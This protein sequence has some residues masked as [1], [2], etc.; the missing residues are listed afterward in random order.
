MDQE[1]DAQLVQ[2][3]QETEKMLKEADAFIVD[4]VHP[5]AVHAH[6]RRI[7]SIRASLLAAVERTEALR[8]ELKKS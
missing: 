1:L 6:L 7:V 3:L 4:K 5:L 8:S 2:L